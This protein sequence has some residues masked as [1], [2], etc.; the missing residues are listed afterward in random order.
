MCLVDDITQNLQEAVF[1]C[2]VDDGDALR[3]RRARL[4]EETSLCVGI[5]YDNRCFVLVICNEWR[6]ASQLDLELSQ[7]N[8]EVC[9]VN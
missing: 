5:A 1:A 7:I 4:I 9:F 2:L 3:E 6:A 8:A